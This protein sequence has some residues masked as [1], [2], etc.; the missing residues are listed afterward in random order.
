MPA[1]LERDERLG[2]RKVSGTFPT[3]RVINHT[4]HAGTTRYKLWIRENY[5]ANDGDIG[6]RVGRRAVL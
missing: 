6:R 5:F 4:A 3:L 2:P 1:F